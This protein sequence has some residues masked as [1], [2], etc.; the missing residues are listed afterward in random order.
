M[1][2]T[3]NN[4]SDFG[5]VTKGSQRKHGYTISNEMESDIVWQLSQYKFDFNEGKLIGPVNL[6]REGNIKCGSGFLC[7][8]GSFFVDNFVLDGRVRMTP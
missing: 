8:K 7:H 5:I 3:G 6:E 1:A 2:V 4:F